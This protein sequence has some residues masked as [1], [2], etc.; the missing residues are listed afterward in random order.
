MQKD[1]RYAFAGECRGEAVRPFSDKVRRGTTNYLERGTPCSGQESTLYT[2]TPHSIRQGARVVAYSAEVRW[3]RW[4][5][6]EDGTRQETLKRA[7]RRPS[8]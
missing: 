8:R 7:V 5:D 4:H 2:F 3:E 1:N 6:M